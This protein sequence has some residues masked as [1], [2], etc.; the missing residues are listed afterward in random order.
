MVSLNCMPTRPFIYTHTPIHTQYKGKGVGG[1]SRASSEG[2]SSIAS[3][4]TEL[5]Q[6]KQKIISCRALLPQC[7][8]SYIAFF[9]KTLE[10][11][12][13]DVSLLIS[14]ATVFRDSI[15]ALKNLLIGATRQAD[16][17]EV[18]KNLLDRILES[19]REIEKKREEEEQRQRAATT[20]APRLSAPTIA[21]P[22]LHPPSTARSSQSSRGPSP[23]PSNDDLLSALG[24]APNRSYHR[25]HKDGR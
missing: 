12:E 6:A 2:E 15:S 24:D 20:R 5:H 13:A 22:S 16:V 17:L 21:S 14:R 10:Q 7:G 23:S 9:D 19:S 11:K 4:D 8:E 18:I 1:E 25:T 3:D